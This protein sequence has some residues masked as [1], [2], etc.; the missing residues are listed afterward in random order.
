GDGLD[1][2][3]VTGAREE[4]VGASDRL[5]GAGPVPDAEPGSRV[6]DG[7]LEGQEDRLGVLPGD[8]HL[9]AV[10]GLERVRCHGEQGVRVRRELDAHEVL[11]LRGDDVEEA[12]VLVR[13][14]R[15]GPAA[16]RATTAGSTGRHGRAP[17]DVGRRLEP[18]RV[19]P[20]H[21]VDDQSVAAGEHVALEHPL[22]QV[23]RQDLDDPATSAEV[24]VTA[25]ATGTPHPGGH[26]EHGVELVRHRLRA[27]ARGSRSSWRPRRRGPRTARAA[28]VERG[29]GCAAVGVRRGAH[30]EVALRPDGRED[31]GR[32]AVGVEQLVRAVAPHPL[33]ELL[34]VSGVLAHGRQRTWWARKVPSTRSPSTSCGPVQPFGVRSTI[35]GQRGRRSAAP[36][37][38]RLRP[39]RPGPRAAAWMSSMLA[40]ARGGHRRTAR[41]P[42]TGR[43]PRVRSRRRSV[44]PEATE[45]RG[46]PR[47]D[48]REDGRVR[49]LPAVEVEDRQHGPVGHRVEEG[50]RLPGAGQGTGLG[51]AVTDDARHDEVRVVERRAVRVR[52]R[53]AEL[54]ALVDGSGVS[55]AA[56]DGMPPGT[57]TA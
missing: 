26:V 24:L 8:D 33:L 20:D 22:E 1:R 46:G 4:H 31:P 49:D 43:G 27:T 32:L 50:V 6:R 40:S 15:C 57:R 2:R 13:E 17:V 7:V 35:I 3:H 52:E 55:G 25:R 37:G 39:V 18:L 19:L 16:T 5:L 10:R 34:A 29:G 11:L 44:V 54:A 48:A 47:R 42:R 14:S 51:L 23:L 9:D 56:W 30:A 45:V 28:T 12:R 36:A 41:A 38:C 53:V 21:R